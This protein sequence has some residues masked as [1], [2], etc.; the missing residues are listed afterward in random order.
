MAISM[1]NSLVVEPLTQPNLCPPVNPG[2]TGSP[3]EAGK[4]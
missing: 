3:V 2:L 1:I 4:N